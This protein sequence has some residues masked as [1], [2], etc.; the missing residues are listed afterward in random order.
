[1]YIDKLASVIRNRGFVKRQFQNVNQ[2]VNQN[3]NQSNNTINLTEQQKE[4]LENWRRG[5]FKID[6][7]FDF[8]KDID[9]VA[10]RDMKIV[11]NIG[12]NFM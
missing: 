2:N 6:P 5:G 1:M 8:N 7:A 12:S 4:M 9:I 3:T 10:Y 11:R